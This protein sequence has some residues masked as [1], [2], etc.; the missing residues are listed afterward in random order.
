MALAAPA[1]S[2]G[3]V[4]AFAGSTLSGGSA[5]Y[6]GAL[7]L[8]RG[9]WQV[10]KSF[11]PPG[12]VSGCS[13]VGNGNAWLYGLSHVSPGVGTWRLRG[14]RWS[15]AQTGKFDLVTASEV[16]ADD[17]WAAGAD[18]L[19]TND[20]VAHWNGRSWTRVSGLAAAVPGEGSKV[21][22]WLN[23][24]NAVSRGNVWVAGQLIPRTGTNVNIVLHLSGGKWHK[25]TPGSAGYYLPG[26]VRDGRGGW[27]AI[28]PFTPAPGPVRSAR[29]RARPTGP[30][31]RCQCRAVTRR[32]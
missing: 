30:G 7:R 11:T 8:V 4:W 20:V 23:A 10:S 3:N 32:E 15:R 28:T 12:L 9:K 24:I 14:T 5:Q 22:L 27:W 17:I 29:R 18:S 1:S 16:R 19:G 21:Q 26:A 31:W 6:A 13:V 25:V 2:P